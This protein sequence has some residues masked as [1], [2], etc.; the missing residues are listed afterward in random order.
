MWPQWQPHQM[1]LQT[2]ACRRGR[3]DSRRDNAEPGNLRQNYF[4][5][6]QANR[7]TCNQNSITCNPKTQSVC[8]KLPPRPLHVTGKRLHVTRKALHVIVFSVLGPR[9]PGAARNNQPTSDCRDH[10]VHVTAFSAGSP[11]RA[12]SD[13]GA[14]TCQECFSFSRVSHNAKE[15]LTASAVPVGSTRCPINATAAAWSSHRRKRRLQRNSRRRDLTLP[16]PQGWVERVNHKCVFTHLCGSHASPDTND[17]SFV[18]SPEPTPVTKTPRTIT[19]NAFLA[20]SILVAS[21][22]P[23]PSLYSPV[24]FP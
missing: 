20:A 4:F 1:A 14:S 16:N 3:P 11:S 2:L 5:R 15:G 8:R 9:K 19:Y 24:Q 22:C 6:G 23:L 7:I 13:V 10:A 18:Q 12:P 17:G 21:S